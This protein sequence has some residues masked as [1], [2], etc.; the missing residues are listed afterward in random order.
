M[1]LA[2]DYSAA[3]IDS[4]S[5][6]S[7]DDFKDV[8][9]SL[10]SEWDDVHETCGV[11][12]S[13]SLQTKPGLEWWQATFSFVV[14]V[15]GAGVM[16]LPMI[17]LKGGLI[18]SAI[19]LVLCG[20]A[21]FE[22][23]IAMWKGIM[24]WNHCAGERK[25]IVS[26]EDFGQAGFG[27]IGQCAIAAMLTCYFIGVCAGFVVL[28]ADSVAHLSENFMST[29]SWLLA[30]SPIFVLLAMLPNVTAIAKLVPLAVIAVVVLCSIL[31]TKPVLDAQRWQEWPQISSLHKLWP[32]E[33][34]ALGTV[35]ASLYGGFGINANVP[36][37]LCEMKDPAQFPF[38]FG[39]ALLIVGFVYMAVMGCGYYGYGEFMQEDIVNSLTSFPANETEAFHVPFE[40]WTVMSV[41]SPLLQCTLPIYFSFRIRTQLGAKMSSVTRKILHGFIIVLSLFTI[42]VGFEQSL[43]DVINIRS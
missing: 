33:A 14:V 35:I 15:I 6:D 2:S 22:S 28:I 18:L 40:Q 20:F 12:C 9:P 37:V 3:Q 11:T 7:D 29:S 36:S 32:T 43:I 25:R 39:A 31:V 16:A 41:F 34:E 17:P 13:L 30:L 19:F 26:Y 23:G 5:G 21:I 1:A 27:E 42:T 38:A 24:A 8:L 4:S 10:P